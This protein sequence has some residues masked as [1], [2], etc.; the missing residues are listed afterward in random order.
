[1]IKKSLFYTISGILVLAGVF[2]ISGSQENRVDPTLFILTSNEQKAV[3]LVH[4]IVQAGDSESLS[5]TLVEFESQLDKNEVSFDLLQVENNLQNLISVTEGLIME[6][7]YSD[8]YGPQDLAQIME[9]ADELKSECEES[10]NT[11]SEENTEY[12][13]PA[14]DALYN[15]KKKDLLEIAYRTLEKVS[16]RIDAQGLRVAE[17][18]E[19]SETAIVPEAIS[20]FVT[21]SSGIPT[22]EVVGGAQ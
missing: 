12:T 7:K 8:N 5:T 15:E 19:Q 21:V 9:K 6:Q 20:S 3:E 22:E 10:G 4:E 1:M 2:T 13:P 18:H 14:S 11:T 17:E 16:G